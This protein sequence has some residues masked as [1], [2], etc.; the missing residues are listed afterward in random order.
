M[1]SVGVRCTIMRLSTRFKLLPIRRPISHQLAPILHQFPK[2]FFSHVCRLCWCSQDRSSHVVEAQLFMQQ[3][4]P[5]SFR[6][7]TVVAENN[8]A[9]ATRDVELVRSMSNFSVKVK[10]GY[11]IVR[12]K[13]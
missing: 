1:C 3:A 6:K 10:L 7:Y 9:I 4:R 5:E 11:I 2:R 13:A 12:S 8:V